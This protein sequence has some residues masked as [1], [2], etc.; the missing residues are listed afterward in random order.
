MKKLLFTFVLLL[1][2]VAGFTQQGIPQRNLI[3][4]LDCTGSMHGFNGAP[5]IWEDTKSFLKTELEKEVQENPDARIVILPFQEKVLAPIHIDPRN[6]SWNRHEATLD[7][8]ISN[9][10]ATNI[11]DSWLAAEKYVDQSCENYIVLMTDGHDNIGGS[12]NESARMEHLAEILSQFCG[13]Y[14]NTKGMYVELTKSATL[15]GTI[16]H[17]IDVCDNLHVVDASDGIPSFGCA[18]NDKIVINTRDLP[19]DIELGFSNSGKF[20]ATVDDDDNEL[21]TVSVKNGFINHGRVKLHIESKF[22]DDIEKLNKAIGG[23]EEDVDFTIESEEVVIINPEIELILKALP[24]RSLNLEVDSVAK[25]EKVKPFLWIKGND[26]DTLRWN[27]R[28][29]FNQQAKLNDASAQFKLKPLTQMADCSVLVDNV[30]LDDDSIFVIT[31]QS[32]GIIE[33]V[34]PRQAGDVKSVFTLK[35]VRTSNLD[36][37]NGTRPDFVSNNV[38]CTLRGE[39]TTAMSWLEIAVYIL[40]AL[41][42]LALAV[43]F[44][45]LKK[46]KYPAFRRGTVTISEP[47]FANVMVRGY[48]MIVFTPDATKHQG[49]LNRLFTGAILYHTNT[50]WP[51]EAAITPSGKNNMRFHSQSGRLISDPMPTW[52][53]GESYKII[54]T[55]TGK[56]IIEITIQN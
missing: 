33:L 44:C 9:L 6:L 37:L 54:D 4:V 36:R 27:L 45:F 42:F 38:L 26:Y 20:A 21:V 32:E 46:M 30:V 31:P 52:I 25:T 35:E 13:K 28:P 29:M 7:K 34:V 24:M 11:C 17:V 51:C 43:W 18:S 10:T 41:I 19:M 1:V 49:F 16:R 2:G 40:L 8:Y 53:A 22:G 3:Y 56:K 50:A 55:D 47:Y 15:P 39:T 48:R 12:A 5:D 23:D 14:A